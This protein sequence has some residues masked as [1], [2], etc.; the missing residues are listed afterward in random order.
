[1]FDSGT[2]RLGVIL[3]LVFVL[4]TVFSGLGYAQPER[5]G[6]QTGPELYH[7]QR[8]LVRFADLVT[9]EAAVESLESLGYALRDV[10]DFRPS[11]QFPSGLRLGIVELSERVSVEEAI[12]R[13]SA[14]PGILYAEPDYI[15]YPSGQTQSEPLFPNDTYFDRMWGLHNH[16]TQY[17]DPRMPG[18]QPVDDADIDAPEAWPFHTGGGEVLVAVIDT[19]CYIDHP[20]L[21]PNVWV[22]E[23]EWNGTPGVDDDGNGYIDDFW[24]WNF[25]SDNNQV[26]DPNERD[27]YGYLNDEHGSHVAGTVGAVSNNSMG[28]AGINWDVQIGRAHV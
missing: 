18:G 8:I 3:T 26:F 1:M 17:I 25:F 19:G 15:R 12:S 4:F 5:G 23:V 9:A 2:K 7:P 28:V 6:W 24:G 14:M 22:N 11:A 27:I 13:L 16:N 21:A 10:V 20:D